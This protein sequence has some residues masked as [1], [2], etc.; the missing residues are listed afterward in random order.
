[1]A[2]ILTNFDNV[3]PIIKIV[4]SIFTLVYAFDV[5]VLH[6]R[7]S[8]LGK[9]LTSNV[10]LFT[11]SIFI[12]VLSFAIDSFDK[13]N[14]YATIGEIVGIGLLGLYFRSCMHSFIRKSAGSFIDRIKP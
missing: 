4:V 3:I 9:A 12:L 2:L 10:L 13:A 7:F 6:R 5:L 1:M 8:D 11:V 14:L